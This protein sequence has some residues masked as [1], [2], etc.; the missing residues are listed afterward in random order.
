VPRSDGGALSW[1]L[2]SER[3]R[4]PQLGRRRRRDCFGPR[5]ATSS[6]AARS[7]SWQVH[8]RS[9]PSAGARTASRPRSEKFTAP[10]RGRPLTTGRSPPACG[11]NRVCTSWQSDRAP[12]SRRTSARRR[13]R[14]CWASQR[15][16]RS[17][18]KQ[19][20]AVAG[21]SS[22]RDH[23]DVAEVVVRS[24]A[25]QTAKALVREMALSAATNGR[26]ALTKSW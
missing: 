15:D 6:T 10:G 24:E 4:V 9:I 25:V 17:S 18:K 22:D 12:S 16:D 19:S 26:A 8:T 11:S 21:A 2:L 23:C 1:P 7:Q 14:S 5:A 13:R 3:G 20:C